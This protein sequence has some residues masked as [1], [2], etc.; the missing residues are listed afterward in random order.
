MGLPHVEVRVAVVEKPE[1]VAADGR[2]PPAEES[3][4]IGPVERQVLDTVGIGPPG[5]KRLLDEVRVGA[6]R[7]ARPR[8]CRPSP[9][10]KGRGDWEKRGRPDVP[11]HVVLVDLVSNGLRVQVEAVR[12][13]PRWWPS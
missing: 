11:R 8:V 5:K 6:P 13:G 10:W 4:S 9:G 1:V 7:G 2:G 3:E 12:Q